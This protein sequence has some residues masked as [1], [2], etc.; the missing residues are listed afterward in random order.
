VLTGSGRNTLH[1][2]AR[3]LLTAG[4]GVIVLL[5]SFAAIAG[6][7]SLAQTRLPQSRRAKDALA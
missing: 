6:A 3:D 2:S 4:R 1:A 7:I 5:G